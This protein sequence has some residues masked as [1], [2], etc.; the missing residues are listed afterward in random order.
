MSTF[1]CRVSSVR[2]KNVK[3]YG[4][5]NMFD[6]YEETC[7]SSDVGTP[8]WVVIIYEKE[9]TLSSFKIEFQG[10][11]V[12]KNCHVEA[13]NDRKELTIVES[14]YPK[15]KNGLQYFLLK[16]HVTAKIFKFVFNESTDFFGRIIIYNF[17]LY[18]K[19]KECPD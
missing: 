17:L 16:N 1:E 3:S 5:M 2:E 18:S 13:G 4:K 6:N 7:W 10:G 9:H 19:E 11:F 14:F 8:Q 12:G 15:D